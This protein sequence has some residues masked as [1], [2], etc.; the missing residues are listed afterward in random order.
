[1][2]NVKTMTSEKIFPE[3]VLPKRKRVEYTL[4]LQPVDR[5]AILEQLSYNAGV[6]SMYTGEEN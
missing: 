2:A 3:D 5:V 6:I 1:M 4:E